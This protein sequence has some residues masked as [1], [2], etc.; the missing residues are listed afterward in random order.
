MDSTWFN[1][2]LAGTVTRG[3]M[4]GLGILCAYL[5]A[6]GITVLPPE[7]ASVEPVVA[8]ALAFVLPILAA[9]WSR[10]KDKALLM[11]APPK[12]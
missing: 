1:K 4:W 11:T 8:G 6:K 5:A 10:R 7:A 9:L 12:E 3:V 2:A